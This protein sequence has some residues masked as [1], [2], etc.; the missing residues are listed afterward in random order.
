MLKMAFFTILA[1]KISKLKL[2]LSGLGGPT[3]LADGLK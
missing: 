2:M 3:D 1:Q